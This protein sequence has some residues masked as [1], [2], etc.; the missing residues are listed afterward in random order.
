MLILCR[1][2]NIRFGC[3][4][5]GLGKIDPNSRSAQQN[6]EQ[7]ENNII[8]YKKKCF[9]ELNHL[10]TIDKNR[11]DKMVAKLFLIS[12]ID[13]NR[14]TIFIDAKKYLG[15]RGKWYMLFFGG[16]FIALTGIALTSWLNLYL[17]DRMIS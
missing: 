12:E 7:C 8:E 9:A 10:R 17:V 3:R 15:R 13:M 1:P 5:F 4:T 2:S 11:F 6:V 14:K 16:I